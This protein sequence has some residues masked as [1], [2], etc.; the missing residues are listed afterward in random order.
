MRGTI[1]EPA[2]KTLEERLWP[3][4]N[5]GEPDECWEWTASTNKGYG[6]IGYT[7]PGGKRVMY[8]ASRIAYYVSNGRPDM[9]GLLVRH[10]CDNPPCC[11]PAHLLLGTDADNARDKIERGRANTPRG[12]KSGR[13]KLTVEQVKALREEYAR[14][15]VTHRQLAARYGMAHGTIGALLRGTAWRTVD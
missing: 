6:Q 14:G 8:H 4:V 10:T 5:V 7:L 13:A 1:Y 2:G 11:N 9:T 15:G 3:R 12:E